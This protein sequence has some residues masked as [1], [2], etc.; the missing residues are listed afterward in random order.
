M[1][2]ALG[3]LVLA[4]LPATVTSVRAESKDYEIR[5]SRPFSVGDKYSISIS[6]EENKDN[7]IIIEGKLKQHQI[8]HTTVTLE[9]DEKILGI[10]KQGRITKASY[11]V[12]KCS[13]S[14][15]NKSE[16]LLKKGTVFTAY[17]KEDETV[18]EIDG[19]LIEDK[20]AAKLRSL[21][22]LHKYEESED[23]MFG[24]K[25][26]RKPGD[27]WPISSKA[28]INLYKKH[29]NKKKLDTPLLQKDVSGTFHFDKIL[30]NEKQEYMELI[31]NVKIS[32]HPFAFPKNFTMKDHSFRFRFSGIFPV[33]TSKQRIQSTLGM[34]LFVSAEGTHPRTKQKLCIEN[35]NGRFRI[36]KRS[37]R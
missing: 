11:S 1:K 7:K 21:I 31:G 37:A 9:A 5:F 8:E 32:K 3:L 4:S 30:N 13:F 36:T 28:F 29:L 33:E 14:S 16:E 12:A 2:Y 23:D 17:L 19:K 27:K 15:K 22:S 10:D 24:T 26:R 34:T 20:V 25:A 18:F 6:N 35:E